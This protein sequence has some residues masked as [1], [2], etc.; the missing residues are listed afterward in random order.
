MI[1]NI[2][3]KRRILEISKKYKLSHLG[4]CLTA[5]D[6]IDEIYSIKKPNE[7][8]VLSSGHAG[9]ALYVVLEKYDTPKELLDGVKDYKGLLDAEKIFNHHGVHP[10]RCSDCHLDCSTGSLGQGINIALG[11]A[12]ANRNQ[13]VYTLISDGECSEG[14][15]WEGLRIAQEQNLK[16]LKIYLNF[17]QWGAYKF[18]QDEP[19]LDAIRLYDYANVQIKHTNT[20]DFPFLGGQEAHYITLTDDTYREA[21]NI[22]ETK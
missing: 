17:N 1:T 19:L 10:D 14:S 22:L 21:I 3:L 2:P 15:V 18:I 12:L 9:L 20:F 13:N 11:M 5:V 7:K 4:S 8:F 16:N 6:I